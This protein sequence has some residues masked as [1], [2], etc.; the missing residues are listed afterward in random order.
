MFV[1]RYLAFQS[2]TPLLSYMNTVLFAGLAVL[3][4]HFI[5]VGLMLLWTSN[6]GLHSCACMYACFPWH[7]LEA[8]D[9]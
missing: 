5:S 2:N 7:M 3:S 1:G 4:L 8:V 6:P 9:S